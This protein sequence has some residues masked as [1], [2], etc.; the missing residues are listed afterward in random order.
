MNSPGLTLSSDLVG[1]IIRVLAIGLIV[2]GL[3][4]LLAVAF[5]ESVKLLN[6]QLFVSTTSR[7]AFS[8]NP[9]LKWL[10]V[11]ILTTAGLVVGL[12]LNHGKMDRPR[13]PSDVILAA[14]S[15]LQ[16][17]KLS[18]KD[19]LINYLSS[20]I[21]LG[22]GASMGQYGPI[23][24]MGA[25]LGNWLNRVAK[26]EVNIAIGCGVAAGIATAFNAPIAGVLFAHEVILR[27]YS[28]RAFAP[29]TVASSV[30][31]YLSNHVFNYPP[32]FQLSQLEVKFAPEFFMFVLIGVIGALVA[33]AFMRIILVSQQQVEKLNIPITLKPMLAGFALGVFALQVPEVLGIGG[34]LLQN[35]VNQANHSI[36][37]LSALLLAK[38]AATAL[39]ISFGLAGGVF[40]PALLIGVLFGALFGE[41]TDLFMPEHSAIGIYAICG[42]AAISSP[43]IGAPLTSILIVFE[44]TRSYELTTAVM[45][46]VVFSN[47]VAYRLFGRSLFD[48]QLKARGYDLSDG[49]DQLMLSLKSVGELTQ[50]ATSVISPTTTLFEARQL[51]TQ[52]NNTIAYV[53]DQDEQYLGAVDINRI[54]K[55]EALIDIRVAQARHQ[56][57][58]NVL[59]LDSELSLWEAMN[60]IGNFVGESLPVINSSSGTLQG[61][62]VE[63][64]LINAYM[65]YMKAERAE[66]HAG[67]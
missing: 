63:T 8:E 64:D 4:S 38:I 35:V 45:A 60:T 47:V 18:F 6:N 10:S 11:L 16:C 43:I 48:Y 42:M 32:L 34:D 31:Y 37:Q 22:A 28:L 61:V 12:L 25:T 41:I 67:V 53:V 65:S 21:S 54:L 56:L 46:S 50:R 26:T 27:H 66:E 33:V 30:G 58:E 40:S 57:L 9:S 62:I 7:E 55:L 17:S 13:N 52:N 24:H 59:T 5:I 23:V 49:H 51:L 1:R 3:A 39:C 14:Q 36:G 44:L 29:I 19:G 2:G 15:K 20:I